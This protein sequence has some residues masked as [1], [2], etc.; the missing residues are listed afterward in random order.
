MNVPTHIDSAPLHP[1]GLFGK[2]ELVLFRPNFL[3]DE[4]DAY[5]PMTPTDGAHP[6]GLDETKPGG[7]EWI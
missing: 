5:G 1:A 4:A 3:D 6:G 7:A 2:G